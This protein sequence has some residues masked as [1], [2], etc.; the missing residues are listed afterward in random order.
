MVPL[1]LALPKRVH[2]SYL[3]HVSVMTKTYGL[4]QLIINFMILLVHYFAISID[5]CSLVNKI[6]Q[7]HNFKYTD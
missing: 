5:S 7:L 6:L 4:L 1:T 2:L 3:R